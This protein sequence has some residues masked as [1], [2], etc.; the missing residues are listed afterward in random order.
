MKVRLLAVSV[1]IVIAAFLGIDSSDL[2]WEEALLTS[3]DTLNSGVLDATSE[4]VLVIR[5]ID[6]DT[7]EIETGEK[8]RYI[9]VDTP[10]T[11]H[12]RKK[13]ECYGKEASEF[14]KNL[15]EG[16]RVRLEKD[17][18][19]TDRYGRLLRYV[20]VGET[21]VNEHLVSQGYAHTVSFPPDIKYQQVLLQAQ[22]SA[23][24]NVLGLWRECES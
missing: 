1:L 11:K 2:F 20:Y 10:E 4:G 5:V 23:R 14:N 6:G 7:I 16:R 18:S 13:V 8:V 24:E 3:E 17:V 22:K 21:F 19:D 15:V 9:G 12:P